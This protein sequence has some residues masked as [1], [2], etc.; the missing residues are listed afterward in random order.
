VLLPL[1]AS[2]RPLPL[3]ELYALGPSLWDVDDDEDFVPE[4][5]PNATPGRDELVTPAMEGRSKRPR[6]GLLTDDGEVFDNVEEQQQ[7]DQALYA[8]FLRATTAGDDLGDPADEKDDSYDFLDDVDTNA[9]ELQLDREDERG[10]GEVSIEEVADLKRE[11]WQEFLE[12]DL[13]N[14]VDNQLFSGVGALSL[15]GMALIHEKPPRNDEDDD[16]DDEVN[17]NANISSPAKNT[18]TAHSLLQKAYPVLNMT[19]PAP[20]LELRALEPTAQQ[21]ATI[22]TQLNAHLQLLMQGAELAQ[23][24]DLK[25]LVH[26]NKRMLQQVQ[27][28]FMGTQFQTA[29]ITRA[30]EVQGKGMAAVEKAMGDLLDKALVIRDRGKK[31]HKRSGRR[32]KSGWWMGDAQDQLL[33]LGVERMNMERGA[34]AMSLIQQYF[35]PMFDATY[36]ERRWKSRTIRHV[37]ENSCKELYRRHRSSLVPWSEKERAELRQWAQLHPEDLTFDAAMLGCASLHW[38]LPEHIQ[39][40]WARMRAQGGQ[41]DEV[42]I[43]QE[44]ADAFDHENIDSDEMV[45]SGGEDE[46]DG[47]A[48]VDKRTLVHTYKHPRMAVQGTGWTEEQDQ[49]LL[50][51]LRDGLRPSC[52]PNEE[53]VNDCARGLGKTVADVLARLHAW[54]VWLMWGVS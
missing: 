6:R 5:T 41:Q 26:L 17:D 28:Q 53:Q 16:Y 23:T 18:R 10:L 43:F 19:V 24:H 30:E 2:C 22:Q 36:V 40:E 35:F 52:T 44:P 9:A 29:I 1:S 45:Q 32:T 7:A 12:M 8:S 4:L 37:A 3:D 25:D 34:R 51:V 50:A 48:I 20:N 14:T 46:E 13:L 27:V 47:T 39:A 38:R 49:R 54:K 33:A 11:A 42:D 31:K 15:D 21:V